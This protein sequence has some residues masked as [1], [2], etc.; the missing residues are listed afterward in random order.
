MIKIKV[1]YDHFLFVRRIRS[2]V[3]VYMQFKIFS[4]AQTCF[5]ALK[6]NELFTKNQNCQKHNL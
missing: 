3:S 6:I 5:L 2:D 1:F 4:D